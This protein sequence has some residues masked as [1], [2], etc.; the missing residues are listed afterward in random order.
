[1][2]GTRPWRLAL[3]EG[4]FKGLRRLTPEERYLSKEYNRARSRV[5][6]W[7]LYQASETVNNVVLSYAADIK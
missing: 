1:M 2:A 5:S 4:P 3:G 7:A 6:N